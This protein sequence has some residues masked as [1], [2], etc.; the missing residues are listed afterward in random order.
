MG[1]VFDIIGPVMIGPSSS[2]TAGAV[3][4]GRIAR[5]AFGRVPEKIRIVLYGSFGATYKGHG[6]DRAIVAGVL[7][8]Y[9]HSPEVKQALEIARE[10]G[11]VVTIAVEKDNLYHPNTA[12]IELNSGGM[13]TEIVGVSLGGGAVSIKEVFGFS[14]DISGKYNTILCSYPEQVGMV[15]RVTQIL[16]AEGINI[17]FMEVS[18]SGRKSNALMVVEVD[19][20]IPEDVLNKVSEVSGMLGVRYI[21]KLS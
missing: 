21:R 13:S 4:L 5:Q 20:E 2:H 12:R 16:A 19:D 6:T 8:Y 18:R 3:N 14:I 10:L 11:I 1:S 15:A 9:P 17:A 7:G